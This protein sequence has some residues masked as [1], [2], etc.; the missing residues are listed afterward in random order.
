MFTP[1]YISIAVDTVGLLDPVI[2]LPLHNYSHVSMCE[3]ER[4]G[5]GDCLNRAGCIPDIP[6]IPDIPGVTAFTAIVAGVA[7]VNCNYGW[8]VH[9]SQNSLAEMQITVIMEMVQ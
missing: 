9:I 1:P 6:D 5:V 8:K 7:T 3:W 2:A 4:R